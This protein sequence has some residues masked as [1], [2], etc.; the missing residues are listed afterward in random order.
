MAEAHGNAARTVTETLVEEVVQRDPNVEKDPIV[1]DEVN[2]E[3]THASD[4]AGKENA[5]DKDEEEFDDGAEEGNEEVMRTVEVTEDGAGDVSGGDGAEIKDADRQVGEVAG[6]RKQGHEEDAEVQSDTAVSEQKVKSAR[7]VACSQVGKDKL[8]AIN[9][10]ASLEQ[11][12]QASVVQEDYV[13]AATLKRKIQEVELDRDDYS[14]AATTKE[15][16]QQ[17]KSS[18]EQADKCGEALQHEI[19]ALLAKED[20]S[21]AAAIKEKLQQP[22]PSS[23]HE[24]KQVAKGREALEQELHALLAMEDYSAAAAIKRGKC[25]R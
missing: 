12:L 16:L 5:S 20:Y 19:L 25:R 14:G 24:E 9:V 23:S 15:N 7:S 4:N 18:D 17:M 22:K 21:A 3:E 2:N 1:K 11:Q 10:L 8:N 13:G 6:K